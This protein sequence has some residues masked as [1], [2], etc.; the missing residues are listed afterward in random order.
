MFLSNKD[1]WLYKKLNFNYPFL[2]FANFISLIPDFLVTFQMIFKNNGSRKFI[3]KTN[4]ILQIFCIF[5]SILCPF[6]IISL[7]KFTPFN[8]KKLAS[9]NIDRN[10]LVFVPKYLKKQ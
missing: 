3:L 10:I 1:S 8:K 6:F 4:T 9:Q 2:I 5:L 7:I